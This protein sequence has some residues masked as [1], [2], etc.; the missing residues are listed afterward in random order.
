MSRNKGSV[1]AKR[2][3]TDREKLELFVNK[4]NELQNTRLVKKGC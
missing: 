4:V 3:R 2:E 1:K